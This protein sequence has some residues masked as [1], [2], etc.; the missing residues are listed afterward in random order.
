MDYSA[1][2]FYPEE[3]MEALHGDEFARLPYFGFSGVLSGLNLFKS[4]RLEVSVICSKQVHL[5]E[6]QILLA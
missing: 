1:T 6:K 3:D 2:S 5:L 4:F